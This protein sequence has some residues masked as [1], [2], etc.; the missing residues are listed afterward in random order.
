M[1][2]LLQPLRLSYIE[3]ELPVL[4]DQARLHSLT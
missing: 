3:P 4:Y 1:K 2:D